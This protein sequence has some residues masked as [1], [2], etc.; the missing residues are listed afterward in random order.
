MPDTTTLPVLKLGARGP[1]VRRLVTLLIA[2]GMPLAPGDSFDSRVRQ[3]V[4][5]FQRR[6]VDSIGHPLTVDGIVGPLTWRAL[7]SEDDSAAFAALPPAVTAAPSGNGGTPRG[8]AALAAALGEVAAGAREVGGN[9]QGPFVTKYFRNRPPSANPNDNAW[10]AAFVS[11]CFAD[12]FQAPPFKYTFGARDMRNQFRA[13][14]WILPDGAPLQPGDVAFWWRGSPSGTLGHVGLIHSEADGIVR[15][16]EGNKGNFPA[17]VRD[18][19]YPRSDMTGGPASD[20]QPRQGLLGF[21][22]VPAGA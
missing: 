2:E 3:A 1:E 19:T 20:G 4:M 16:N 6:H 21:G 9:N 12:G 11:W 10:C 8:K 15:T 22:R 5:E 18:F 7:M 17:P 13:K 14:G